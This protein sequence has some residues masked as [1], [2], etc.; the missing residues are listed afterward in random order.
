[1]TPIMAGQKQH[2][3]QGLKAEDIATNEFINQNTKLPA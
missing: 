2:V 3:K 1:M